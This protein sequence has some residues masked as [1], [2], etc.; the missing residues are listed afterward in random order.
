MTICCQFRLC[1]GGHA[2][3]TREDTHDQQLR[4]AGRGAW[5][6]RRVIGEDLDLQSALLLT[7]SDRTVHSVDS[8]R[9]A[10]TVQLHALLALALCTALLINDRHF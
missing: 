3:C 8:V 4:G 5:P 2:C 9:S 6:A 1:T 10:C 7:V